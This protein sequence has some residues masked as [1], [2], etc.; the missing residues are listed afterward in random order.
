MLNVIAFFF[1]MFQ[2]SFFLSE[3][4]VIRLNKKKNVSKIDI[5]LYWLLIINEYF[6]SFH[7]HLSFFLFSYLIVSK[8]IE[9][10]SSDDSESTE[11]TRFTTSS[12]S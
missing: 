12:S 4:N 8:E 10:G 2:V 7:R 5:A 9:N 3:K 11:S 1:C 6:H